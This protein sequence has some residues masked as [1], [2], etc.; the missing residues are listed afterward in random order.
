MHVSSITKEKHKK[1]INTKNKQ[2]NKNKNKCIHL[3]CIKIY[4]VKM[5]VKIFMQI[6][7]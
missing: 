5:L 6:I 3:Q 2:K 7:F 1:Y 4:F